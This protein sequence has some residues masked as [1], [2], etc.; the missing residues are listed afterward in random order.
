MGGVRAG[1]RWWEAASHRAVGRLIQHT[2]RWLR[3]CWGVGGWGGGDTGDPPHTCEPPPAAR[4]HMHS[5]LRL[6]LREAKGRGHMR[7][8]R[9]RQPA[10]L[11]RPY[12]R[13]DD[14]LQAGHHGRHAGGQRHKQLVGRRARRRRRP[15]CPGP[16][17]ARRLLGGGAVCPAARCAVPYGAPRAGRGGGAEGLSAGAVRAAA[18]ALEGTGLPSKHCNSTVHLP[19]RT[20]NSNCAVV[21]AA[22]WGCHPLQAEK[23]IRVGTRTCARRQCSGCGQQALDLHGAALQQPQ[24]AVRSRLGRVGVDGGGAA[25]LPARWGVGVGGRGIAGRGGRDGG[26][27]CRAGGCTCLQHMCRARACG[28]QLRQRVSAQPWRSVQRGGRPNRVWTGAAAASTEQ[29]PARLQCA[30]P[31]AAAAGWEARPLPLVLL[32]R[33]AAAVACVASVAGRHLRL[34]LLAHAPDVVLRVAQAQAHIHM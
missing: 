31:A 8:R 11:R 1:G 14:E 15:P 30:L 20:P 4:M 5:C 32:V 9:T 16:S 6:Q 26:L 2:M 17:G 28:M 7:C 21:C 27:G 25:R 29:A 12:P 10:Y 3:C 23:C 18:A 34:R 19:A 33:A 24:Q 13:V 22:G